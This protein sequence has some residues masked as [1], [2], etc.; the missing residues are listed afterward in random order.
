MFL[1]LDES[2]GSTHVTIGCLC[3]PQSRMSSLEKAFIDKRLELK[4]WGEVKW[5]K[6]T[7]SYL[8]KYL[9]LLKTYL[10]DDEVTYHSWTYK[11]PSSRDRKQYYGENVSEDQVVFRQAYLLLRSVIRKCKNNGYN[12]SFYIVADDSGSGLVEYRKTNELLSTDPNIRGETILDFCS[13]GNSAVLS[14]LQAVDLCTG[15]VMSCYDSSFNTTNGRKLRQELEALNSG[16]PINFSPTRLPSL[17][18]AKLHHCLN[19]K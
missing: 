3:I 19:N 17:T 8:P 2:I 5:S 10:Y 13:T 1:A 14:A 9:E 15:A 4:C 11:I 6:I 12:G 16:V 7:T 18:D